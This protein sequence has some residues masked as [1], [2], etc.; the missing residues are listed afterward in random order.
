M[1]GSRAGFFSSLFDSL[2]EQSSDVYGKKAF[3]ALFFYVIFA[4]VAVVLP[5]IA[6]V[7][8][9]VFKWLSN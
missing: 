4:L 5:I 3:S 2:K 7:G 9:A 6:I 1:T 8:I